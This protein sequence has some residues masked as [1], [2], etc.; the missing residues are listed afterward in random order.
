M[1]C[2]KWQLLGF[3]PSCH[4]LP[5]GPTICHLTVYSPFSIST[6]CSLKCTPG[7]ATC[8]RKQSS[9]S[10][11]WATPVLPSRL[12]TGMLLSEV[13]CPLSL[14]LYC[15]ELPS[16][17]ST[18]ITWFLAKEAELSCFKE[19]IIYTYC[20]KSCRKYAEKNRHYS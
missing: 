2:A 20:R 19:K 17:P 4:H 8:L 16:R 5:V 14:V 12:N 13:P 18:L 10:F 6:Y 15:S 9:V 1:L 11:C 3:V 7:N